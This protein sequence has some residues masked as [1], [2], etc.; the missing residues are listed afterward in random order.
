VQGSARSMYGAGTSTGKRKIAPLSSLDPIPD[1]ER[2]VEA[3]NGV[4]LRVSD[5]AELEATLRRGMEI[6]RTERRSV[7]INVLGA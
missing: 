4:G 7:L 1:F 2:Y 6:V 5:R 3:S